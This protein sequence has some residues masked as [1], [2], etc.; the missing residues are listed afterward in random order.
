M[1]SGH[2]LMA[3]LGDG[4]CHALPHACPAVVTA[5]PKCLLSASLTKQC[6]V[7]LFNIG[8]VGAFYCELLLQR[9]SY[10]KLEIQR[11][12][13]K[14]LWLLAYTY[15]TCGDGGCVLVLISTHRGRALLS[16]PARFLC[17]K[18]EKGDS[19]ALQ[20]QLGQ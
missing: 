4:Y 19:A 2:R 17:E 9:C 3:V 15:Q 11:E 10:P 8:L 16:F 13:E 6:R 5:S 12:E 18:G 14:S 20:A 7:Q 1:C